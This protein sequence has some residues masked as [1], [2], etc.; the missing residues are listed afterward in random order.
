MEIQHFRRLMENQ[1]TAKKSRQEI[2]DF[3]NKYL[4]VDKYGANSIYEYFKEQF[5]F[6][7]I[8]SE[9]KIIVEHYTDGNGKYVIFHTLFGRRTNDVLARA[10]AFAVSRLQH[11]DVELSITDNG[12][13]LQYKKQIQA[14]RAFS[15]VKSKDLRKIMALALDKTEILKRRFRHCATRALMILRTYKGREKTVGKQQV[16]SMLLINAVKRISNDFPILKEARREV[17][18]DLMDIDNAKW[19]IEQIESKK[20]KIKEVFTDLPSP[21][22][23]N[24][25]VQGYTDIMRIEDKQE[26]L[27]RM[28]NMILAKISL[29]ERK[30]LNKIN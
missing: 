12:F 4:Y 29:K 2:L 7:E 15:Y 6:S 3:I 21:F 16:S 30:N 20:I 14:V 8:P 27:K 10:L 1:F 22:A 28:H 18:E 24:L 25:I 23:F 9:K 26:F 13:F 11:R 19:I 5:L 17:L